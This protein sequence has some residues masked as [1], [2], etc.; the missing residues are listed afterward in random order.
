MTA[1]I[2]AGV[3]FTVAVGLL[4]LGAVGGI[5]TQPGS[6]H[7]KAVAELVGG[8]VALAFGV[9]VLTGRVAGPSG[10]EAPDVS[11]RWAGLRDRRLTL[12]GAALA[13]PATHIPGLFYLIALNVIAGSESKAPRAVSAVLI[14]NALWFA[15][16]IAA[17][18]ICI[19]RPAAAQGVVSAA[20][21]WT[22]RH[23]RVIVIVASLGV[24]AILVVRAVLTL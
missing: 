22:R 1:Y 11:P 6:S 5:G 18:A 24:G 4:I 12:R 10:N 23:A 8:L 3:A 15:L 14:F 20:E 19:A 13:G 16:P 9:L 7:T 2:A 17:L 21:A